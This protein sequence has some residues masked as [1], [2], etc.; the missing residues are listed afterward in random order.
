MSYLLFGY[1]FFVAGCVFGLI[2]AGLIVK[3]G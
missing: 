1:A 3:A 2:C